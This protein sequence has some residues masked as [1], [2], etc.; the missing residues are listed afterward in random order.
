VQNYVILRLAV[1]LGVV[2]FMGELLFAQDAPYRKVKIAVSDQ[3]KFQQLAAEGLI[4]DHVHAVRLP[5]GRLEIEAILDN[6]EFAILENSG[7]QYQISEADVQAAIAARPALSPSEKKA[8]QQKY[9]VLGFEFGSMGGF[10]TLSEVVAELDSMRLLFPNL[11]SEKF[12]IGQTIQGREI[13]AVK[14]SDNPDIDEDEPEV[15]Y[16]ALHHCREPQGM[17]TLIYFMYYL[18]EH[19]DSD[20]EAAYLVNERELYFIPVMNPDGY[21]YNQ[22]ISPNGGGMWRKNRRNNGNGTFGVDLN[23]N[24]GYAWGYDNI[25]SSNDPSSNTYRGTAPFSE[26]E[27]QAYRDFVN[28]RHFKTNLSYHTYSNVLIYPFGYEENLLTPDSVLFDEYAALLTRDNQYP[29]GTVNQTIG[30]VANGGTFDWMY[31]EQNSKSKVFSMT[32]EVGSSADGFWPAQSRIYPLAQENLSA[33]LH[34]A[35]LAGAF[36]K[37]TGVTVNEGIAGDGYFDR[38]EEVAIQIRFKNLGL[39]SSAMVS[40][41]ISSIDGDLLPVAQT[42]GIINGIASRVDALSDTAY[43]QISTTSQPGSS[44][45]LVVQYEFSDITKIDTLRNFMVTGIPSVLFVNTAEE[46]MLGWLPGQWGTTNTTFVSPNNS[47][48]DSPLGDY[49]SNTNNAMIS[50]T[51]I[52]L[53]GLDKVFLEYYSKWDIEKNYDFAQVF[54]SADGTSWQPLPAPRMRDGSGQGV[55]TAGEPGYDGIQS[56]WVKET[57]DISNFVNQS[58]ALKFQLRSDGFVEA[59]GWFLDDIRIVTY[60]TAVGV[61]EPA[62][63]EKLTFDLQQNYPNPFNPTTTIRYSVPKTENIKVIVY[64]ALGEKVTEL[65]NAIHS[66]GIYQIEFDAANLSSGIYFLTMQGRH[67]M[68]SQ[69]ML[70][71]R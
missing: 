31:G 29:Y 65:V 68:K 23:R 15:L 56:D 67:R 34:L 26:P 60:T 19:Y 27:T 11:V 51:I 54:L 13:W 69:K 63:T 39:D 1:V 43:F 25:G 7:L 64:N 49:S 50:E 61:T 5:N 46:G 44:P 36:I 33:N 12:S 41:Q 38:G 47:F 57:I 37:P 52:N 32:P 20:S 30:Y 48:A 2:L 6:T 3:Q 9:G 14:I 70:L 21:T 71:T 62:T 28:N 35:W 66:P 42:S 8:I 22:S 17:M 16:D 18:L 45:A 58:V 55:Q 59:D 10:Y 4:F 53:N 40:Y 24:Y